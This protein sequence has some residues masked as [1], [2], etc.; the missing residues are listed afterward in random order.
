MFLSQGQMS[1]MLNDLEK[2]GP[3]AYGKFRN[4]LW[5]FPVYQHLVEKLDNT[6]L[7]GMFYPLK[8]F[9]QEQMELVFANKTV[10]GSV[11]IWCDQ[12]YT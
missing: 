1:K 4:V 10:A 6:S 7:P 5:E 11:S 8:N 9:V 2:R 3:N 12:P